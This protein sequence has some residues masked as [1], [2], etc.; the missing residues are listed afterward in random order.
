MIQE[1]ALKELEKGM[2]HLHRQHYA[3]ALTSFKTIVD[4][5]PQDKELQDRAH[6]YLK[7]CQS[8]LDRE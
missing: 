4:G 8:R 6:V 5:Y 1:K 3:D 7:I 2:N